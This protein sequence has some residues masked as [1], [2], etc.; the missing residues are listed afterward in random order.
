MS[1]VFARDPFEITIQQLR[2][3]VQKVEADNRY[4]VRENV[5]LWESINER[6]ETIQALQA[7]IAGL[8][9]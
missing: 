2:D 3:V 7:R 8:S 4:L 6:D 1:A 9:R 5:S